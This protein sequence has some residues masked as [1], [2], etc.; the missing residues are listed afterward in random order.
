MDKLKG[1]DQRAKGTRLKQLKGQKKEQDEK[2]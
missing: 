2:S 1:Q